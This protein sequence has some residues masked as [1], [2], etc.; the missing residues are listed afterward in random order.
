[1]QRRGIHEHLLFVGLLI[2]AIVG[3]SS[4]LQVRL[5]IHVAYI[6]FGNRPCRLA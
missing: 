6:S 4:R 2:A 1:M 3:A 5:P